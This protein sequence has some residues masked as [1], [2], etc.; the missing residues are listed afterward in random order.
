MSAPANFVSNR[1]RRSFLTP[2]GLRKAFFVF[3]PTHQTVALTLTTSTPRCEL[4]SD[5]LHRRY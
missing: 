1:L 3:H 2:R 4:F 5:A